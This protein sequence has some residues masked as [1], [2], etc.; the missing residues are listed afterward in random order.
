MPQH[1]HATMTTAQL[2]LLTVAGHLD[3][4]GLEQPQQQLDDMPASG[5]AVYAL[6]GIERRPAP[7]SIMGLPHSIMGLSWVVSAPN[8]GGQ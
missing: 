6:N 8:P 2:D 5:P 1:A 7:H 4:D 3:L